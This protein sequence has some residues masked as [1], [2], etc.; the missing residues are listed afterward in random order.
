MGGAQP[1]RRYIAALGEAGSFSKAWLL[2]QTIL[3]NT[4]GVAV[5]FSRPSVSRATH[6]PAIRAAAGLLF[7]LTPPPWPSL[8]PQSLPKISLS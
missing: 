6:F 8:Q 3:P 5:R 2:P 7:W 4:A 1:G